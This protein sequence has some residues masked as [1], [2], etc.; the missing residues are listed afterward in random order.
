MKYNNDQL[1]EI[2]IFNTLIIITGII[3]NIFL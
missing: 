2:M 3:L 1:K